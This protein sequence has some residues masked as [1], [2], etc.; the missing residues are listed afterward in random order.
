MGRD[1]L[2]TFVGTFVLF[3]SYIRDFPLALAIDTVQCIAKG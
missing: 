2:I 3:V 1:C